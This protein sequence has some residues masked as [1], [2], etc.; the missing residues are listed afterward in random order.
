M[1]R[2][3][4]L[5]LALTSAA[6]SGAV[7]QVRSYEVQRYEIIVE[8]GSNLGGRIRF[9]LVQRF[10]GSSRTEAIGVNSLQ[11]LAHWS[12]LLRSRSVIV[13]IDEGGR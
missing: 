8:D 1:I 13:D 6:T 10:G 9:E 3:A 7:A 11:D 4:M 2:H 12:E 5:A